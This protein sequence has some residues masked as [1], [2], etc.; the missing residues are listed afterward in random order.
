MSLQNI[1][2]FVKHHAVLV[3]ASAAAVISCFFVLPDKMYLAYPDYKVLCLLFCLMAVIAGLQKA[4]LFSTLSAAICANIKGIRMMGIFLTLLCFFSAMFVT[5]DVALITF[6]PFAILTLCGIG[7]KDLVIFTVTLQTVAANLGSMATPIGNPQNLYLY[8]K[9]QIPAAKFFTL[10]L[11]VVGVSLV[12][13]CI[14]WLFVKNKPVTPAKQSEGS[15]LS[16]KHVALYGVMFL[17]CL[18]CVMRVLDYRILTVLVVLVLLIFDRKLFA[19]VDYPLLL[20]FLAFF[21]FVGNL[22]RIEWISAFLSGLMVSMPFWV[23]LLCSQVISNVP[24]AMLLA[25]FCENA[26]ALILGVNVGGLGT[27]IASL[28]SL[29]SF[30]Q[31]GKME[32][33]DK[34]KYLMVFTGINLLFL[35]V[36]CVLC[37]FLL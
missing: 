15:R 3:I 14:C 21:I 1:V 18:L 27:L 26:N 8:E 30:E 31:Y 4:G 10:T 19:K 34:G 17:L 12:L 35:A 9:Y 22:T 32:G 11:P 25:S 5:N 33:A 2:S 28:A 16:K 7:R 24:A 29:I 23:S 36:L 6:V 20:T 13:L 37:L